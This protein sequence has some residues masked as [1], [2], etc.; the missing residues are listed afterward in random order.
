M[1]F[2]VSKLTR[3]DP[4]GRGAGVFTMKERVSLIGGTC[5]IDSRPGQGTLV[6]VKVPVGGRDLNE[7]NQGPHCR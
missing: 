5:R 4:S 3:V 1:G 6:F 7:E 2:D